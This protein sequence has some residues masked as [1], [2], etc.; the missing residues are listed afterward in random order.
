MQTSRSKTNVVR[1]PR[2]FAEPLEPRRLFFS[3][4]IEGSSGPDAISIGISGNDILFVLN[5]V[6]DTRS[7]ALIDDIVINGNG[8]ADVFSIINNFSQNTIVVNGGAGNDTI[9]IGNGDNT[10]DSG[11]GITVN[12]GSETDRLKL[13]DS[14]RIGALQYDILP[15]RVDLHESFS[16]FNEASFGYG[17]VENLEIVGGSSFSFFSVQGA[18]GANLILDAGTS[19]SPGDVLEIDGNTNESVTL[20]PAPSPTATYQGKSITTT[21]IEQT[22]IEGLNLTIQS[23]AADEAY[24]VTANGNYNVF[25]SAGNNIAGDFSVRLC[26][27]VML[28]MAAN[29]GG[30]G[31]DFVDFNGDWVAS[32]TLNINAGTGIN[33]LR[34]KH[35]VKFSTEFGTLK[36]QN[37]RLILLESAHATLSGN[38]SAIA[39]VNYQSDAALLDLSGTTAVANVGSFELQ[40][41]GGSLSVALLQAL[42]VTTAFKVGAHELHKL[43]LGSL[44]ILSIAT[45]THAIGAKLSVESGVANIDSDP[46]AGG[47]LNLGVGLLAGA[48]INFGTT[49]H[50][51]D[52]SITDGVAKIRPNGGR[53]LVADTLTL[54][55]TAAVDVT[56]NSMIVRNSAGAAILPTLDAAVRSGFN[57]GAWTGPGIRS[58][59]AASAPGTA[60]GFGPATD[61]LASL[62][63][64]FLGQSVAAGSIVFRHTIQGDANLDRAVNFSD[65]VILSQNYDTAGRSFTRGNFDFDVQGKVDFADLVLVA[66]HYN[67]A[68]AI[69][70]DPPAKRRALAKDVIR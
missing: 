41:A 32:D 55:G 44:N 31:S 17:G 67:N 69:T 35:A 65:L 45:Q 6:S 60:V 48:S 29:D 15:T 22:L 23:A 68:L 14:G 33:D 39:Q 20:F 13:F 66:Q 21:A 28:D 9:N 1:P 47:G 3:L 34:I 36:G 11:G 52:L 49:A 64:V 59:S 12:G 54:A 70:A 26:T 37:V 30:A 46:S 53:V 42:N 63:G 10:A 19:P 24:H 4:T 51:K 25:A 43:G 56:D 40:S 8:G 50:L 5:G 62:P 18:P 61:L 38:Q 27:S 16:S 7:N 2:P 57:N 58:S